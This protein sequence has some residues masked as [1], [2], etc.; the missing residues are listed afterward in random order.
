MHIFTVKIVEYKD[1]SVGVSA[2]SDYLRIFTYRIIE[3][4]Q[5]GKV[6]QDHQVQPQPNYSTLTFTTHR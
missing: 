2:S 6:L 4:A 3:F 5:V 1:D